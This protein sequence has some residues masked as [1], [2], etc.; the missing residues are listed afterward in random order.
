MAEGNGVVCIHVDMGGA[1]GGAMGVD[2]GVAV[3]MQNATRSILPC[4]M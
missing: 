1:V 2:M 4:V 3:D